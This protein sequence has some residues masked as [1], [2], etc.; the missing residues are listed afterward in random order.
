[1][2]FPLSIILISFIHNHNLYFG[3][4][5]ITAVRLGS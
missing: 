5:C 1:M 3:F 2:I 4:V